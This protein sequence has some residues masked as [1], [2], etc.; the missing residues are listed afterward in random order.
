MNVAVVDP[1]PEALAQLPEPSGLDCHWYEIVP[2][3]PVMATVIVF[4]PPTHSYTLV[5][6]VMTVISAEMMAV[7][8][9]LM[10]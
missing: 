2:E 5:G 9:L 10:T 7:A 1:V 6:C 4:V 8:L 3:P